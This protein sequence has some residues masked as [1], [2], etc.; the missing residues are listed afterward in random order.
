MSWRSQS[1]CERE[2]GAACAWLKILEIFLKIGQSK[3]WK[4]K[5]RIYICDLSNTDRVTYHYALHNKEQKNTAL[6]NREEKT[7]KRVYCLTQKGRKE[8]KKKKK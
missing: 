5:L 2:M 3:K 7:G 1:V 6:R 8:W 4:E